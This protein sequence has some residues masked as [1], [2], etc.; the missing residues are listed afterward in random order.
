MEN[1]YFECIWWYQDNVTFISNSV[2]IN[3]CMHYKMVQDICRCVLLQ[4]KWIMVQF[5]G[6]QAWVCT[7]FY[8][9]FPMFSGFFLIKFLITNTILYVSKQTK[10]SLIAY[11]FL[12]ILMSEL[13]MWTEWW[14]RICKNRNTTIKIFKNVFRHSKKTLLWLIET[15][16]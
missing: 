7:H 1:A 3:A 13:F 16:S 14:G 15:K 12:N 4:N 6:I 10:L 11:P 5:S 8:C 2:H 9:F